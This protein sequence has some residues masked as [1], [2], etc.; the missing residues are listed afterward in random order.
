MLN[1]AR[2][3]SHCNY[4]R[5]SFSMS[6]IQQVAAFSNLPGPDVQAL[7]VQIAS[8]WR[9]KGF[10]VAGLVAENPSAEGACAAGHL[11]D[12]ASDTQVALAPGSG[13]GTSKPSSTAI[14]QAIQLVRPQIAQADVLII[15]RFGEMEARQHGLW[16]LFV[17]AIV[18]DKPVLTTVL[19][20]Q[21]LVFERYAPQ[22]RYLQPILDDVMTW[23]KAALGS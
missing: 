6:D 13:G 10:C 15:S 14:S 4:I 21:K 17:A 18:A 3:L 9:A 11:R 12:L 5:G 23:S 20:E 1:L 8:A 7:L 22:V 19:V 2:T 16:P